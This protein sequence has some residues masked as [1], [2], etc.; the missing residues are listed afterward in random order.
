MPFVFNRAGLDVPLFITG[1]IEAYAHVLQSTV[2]QKFQ[3]LPAFETV[4]MGSRPSTQSPSESLYD[5]KIRKAMERD[6]FVSFLKKSI[7]RIIPR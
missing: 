4:P 3:N 7:P 6:I 5:S 2:L 1:E